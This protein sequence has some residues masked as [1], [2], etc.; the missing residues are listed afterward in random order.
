MLEVRCPY[1]TSNGDLLKRVQL[2]RIFLGALAFKL[3]ILCSACQQ[4]NADSAVNRQ[5]KSAKVDKVRQGTISSESM[6][7]LH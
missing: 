6:A 2:E 7:L 1:Q 4:S 3:W 5:D